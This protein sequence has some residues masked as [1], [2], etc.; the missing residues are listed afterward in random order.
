VRS[1]L[2]IALGIA[3]ALAVSTNAYADQFTLT[4]C[5]ISG[6]PNTGVGTVTLTYSAGAITVTVA[7]SD[8]TNWG[9]G[10]GNA[11]D[12][13]G[14]D[15]VG[16]G[17]LTYSNFVNLGTASEAI[18]TQ[19]DGFGSF[20]D[21]IGGTGATTNSPVSGFSFTV[22]RSSNPFTSAAD[23]E[24]ANSNGAL[25]AV[26]IVELPLTP[27]GPN[28]ATGFAAAGPNGNPTGITITPE[29]ASLMLLGTGLGVV[30][31]RLRRRKRQ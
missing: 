20:E 26:H 2:G 31:M 30:A 1:F 13:F 24:E 27:G 4:D 15:Q 16:S 9:F 12:L 11:N 22:T 5:N 6:C 10:S 3:G 8:A 7:S 29:P 18:N 19:F 14:F 28:R 21:S 25:F 23:L 17:S